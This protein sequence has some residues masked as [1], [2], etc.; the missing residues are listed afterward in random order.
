M[1]K[2]GV[3]HRDLKME[4]VLYENSKYDASIRL[5]DFGLSQTYDR[6]QVSRKAIGTAYTLSPEIAS[7]TA[8]YTDKTDMWAVGVIAWILLAGDYPF[9]KEA[10]DLE[11]KFKLNKLINA[12]YSFG[13]TWN[14]RGISEDART[15][16]EKCLKKNPNDRWSAKEALGF[17]QKTWLPTMEEHVQALKKH[18]G[19]DEDVKQREKSLENTITAK[20]RDDKLKEKSDE[21]DFN[22]ITRFCEYGSMKKTILT[23]MAH[24]ID[25]KD[26]SRL[27]EI[28]LE[29]DTEDV[30][31][32]SF[33]E[34][35]K[36]FKKINPSAS[37]ETMKKMFQGIDQ[38]NSGQ[39]HY[40]EFIAALAE[41]QGLITKDRLAE[42]F[43][44]IDKEG[45]G[46]ISHDDLKMVL[47]KD[48][49]KKKVDAMIKEADFKKNG[50]VDYEELLELMFDDLDEGGEA[51]GSFNESLRSLEGFKDISESMRMLKVEKIPEQEG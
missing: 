8:T 15:F 40:A 3:Y 25:R 32:L 35:Q 26:V 24:T 13:I 20:R 22:D 23:A 44:R 41:S 10:D 1:H 31:T 33:K 43:D 34:L 7:G 48:Y 27:S 5:I 51:L 2:R 21:I 39:I 17:V 30:G 38:D 46:Y 47:G 4:N 11:D 36:A 28:F 49:D 29:V 16:C 37:E 45:K 19:D 9:V 12:R 14:G 50:Q 42:A 18:Y 6:A